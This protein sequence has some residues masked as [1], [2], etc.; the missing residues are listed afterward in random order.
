MD[1]GNKTANIN[2][3]QQFFHNVNGD[4]S[5][6]TKIIKSS[7]SNWINLWHTG[8]LQPILHSVLRKFGISKNKDASLW[9]FVPNSGLRKTVPRPVARLAVNDRLTTV[10][11]LQWWRDAARCADPSA[12]AKT[13]FETGLS[14]SL[15]VSEQS[16]ALETSSSV[17][18]VGLMAYTTAAVSANS[19]RSPRGVA[20]WTII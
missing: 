12:A 9:H 20:W 8:F 13:C 15:L 5:K 14:H 3:K 16:K 6:T 10:V 7:G 17:M 11:V 2:I 19:S 1:I 4:R 18:V